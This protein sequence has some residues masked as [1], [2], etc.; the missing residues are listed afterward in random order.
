MWMDGTDEHGQRHR[1]SLKTRDW[2]TALQRIAQIEAGTPT[3]QAIAPGT[4]IPVSIAIEKY[5]ADCIARNLAKNSIDAYTNTLKHLGEHFKGKSL[6][7][8]TVDVLTDYR[9]IRA[10]VAARSSRGEIT[11][12]RTFFRF[13]VDREWIAKNPAKSLRL[14]KAQGEP[15]MPFTDKEVTAML[16]A[17]DEIT[18][19]RSAEHKQRTQLRARALLLTLLYSGMR[20]SD[21]ILLER[22]K[23]NMKTGEIFIKMMKT[24][25][26]LF[27]P[28][29]RIA[30]DAL[31]A[32]PEESSIYFFWK[33]PQ[34]CK[35]DS[36][37]ADA[38]RA[39]RRVL[40][41]AGVRNGHPHRFRDT[42]SVTLLNNGIDLRTVQ[43]LLGHTS[44]K[45]TERHYAPFV[46]GTQLLLKKATATLHFGPP[47][48]ARV[49][50]ARV[51]TK[52]HA[53]RNPQGNAAARVLA[54]PKPQTA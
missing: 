29:Q 47:S 32:L 31:R 12:L 13:C 10:T 9:K 26:P 15:T 4:G 46:S 39:I 34:N 49:R 22:T 54:F 53:L 37:K 28:L 41:R 16:A 14:P 21:V 42:F 51:N 52:Q 50:K 33:G 5:L 27:L 7:D 40:K 3:P 8:V 44:I 35:L 19:T 6:A 30:V 38:S 25:E 24:S 18:D 11:E 20:I 48:P 43:L 1:H 36:A 2:N 23:V 17:C 45:T